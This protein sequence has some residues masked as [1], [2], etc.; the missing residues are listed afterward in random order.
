M[1]I[2]VRVFKNDAA[3]AASYTLLGMCEFVKYEGSWPMNITWRLT[4]SIQAK[5]L[6]R[7][8]KLVV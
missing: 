6:S 1:V 3:G 5:Y 8:N 7:T 4:K 2:C